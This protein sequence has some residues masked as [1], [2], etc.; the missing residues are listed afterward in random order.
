VYGPQ[1]PDDDTLRTI[2]DLTDLRICNAQK[3]GL[4]K[5]RF[6]NRDR[7]AAFFDKYTELLHRD[8]RLLWNADKTQFSAMKRDE[9]RRIALVERLSTQRVEARPQAISRAD[10]QYPERRVPIRPDEASLLRVRLHPPGQG[11][12]QTVDTG[13]EIN[14]M[15]VTRS[16]G[17][18]KPGQ[19]RFHSQ[20]F[21][22]WME[23]LS[24]RVVWDRLAGRPINLGR[25]L[26]PPPPFYTR[27]EQ[28]PT[29]ISEDHIRILEP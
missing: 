1:E 22:P 8:R 29:L 20:G 15:I 21:E 23:Q 3:S 5:R 2:C 9:A 17:L 6:W 7:I 26:S 25:A 19:I 4:A 16:E 10:S 24:Y 11:L 27:L 28:D 12:Y 18:D 13:S 14:E